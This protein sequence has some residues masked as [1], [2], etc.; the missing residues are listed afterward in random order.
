[1][2]KVD[3]WLTYSM[4]INVRGKIIATMKLN[5]LQVAQIV[6]KITISNK[7]SFICLQDGS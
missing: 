4:L 3:L 2:N 1:M 7:W 5:M 6:W